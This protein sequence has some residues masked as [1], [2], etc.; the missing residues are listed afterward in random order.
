M[1]IPNIMSQMAS[2]LINNQMQGML[3]NLENQLQKAN[4]QM[5][6]MYQMARQQNANPNDLL[7]QLTSNYDETTMKR[8]KEQAKQFGISDDLLN[9]LKK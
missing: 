8:F 1:Q 4:P 9:Q 3:S 7:T 6:Q 5:F 2:N